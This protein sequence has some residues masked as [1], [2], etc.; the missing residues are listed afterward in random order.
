MGK[1][2]MILALTVMLLPGLPAIAASAGDTAVGEMGDGELIL[3]VLKVNINTDDAATIAASLQGVGLKRAQ[4]IVQYRE[5]NG[6]FRD[7]G[8]LANVKG[9]GGATVA[10]NGKRIVVE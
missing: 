4:A 7:A 6:P 3:E 1:F 8:E 9:I 2:L 10:A 5:T